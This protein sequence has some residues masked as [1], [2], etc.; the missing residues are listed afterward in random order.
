M[1]CITVFIIFLI[2]LISSPL[3]ASAATVKLSSW[4]LTDSGRHLDW[5]GGSKYI[6]YFKKG[7]STWNKYK[8]GV[9]RPDS[10]WVIQDVYISDYSEKSNTCAYT[11]ANGTLHFNKYVMGDLSSKGKQNVATHE[12]GHALGLAHNGSNDIMYKYQ[13]NR[14][15]LSANDKASYKAAYK[16]Y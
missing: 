5:D 12:L 15:S 13:T 16:R 10:I 3:S 1:S 4:W 9:I 6:S 11:S 8:S 2:S 14:I 7:V